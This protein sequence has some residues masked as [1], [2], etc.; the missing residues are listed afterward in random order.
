MSTSMPILA[1]IKTNDNY[2]HQPIGYK[3]ID[4]QRSMGYKLKRAIAE[5]VDNAIDA[6]ARKIQV[7]LLGDKR[8]AIEEIVILDN[9][10]GM[11]FDTLKNSFKLGADRVRSAGDLGYFGMGGTLGSLSFSAQKKT[12]TRGAGDNDFIGRS[13]DLDVCEDRDQWVTREESIIPS[14][15]EEL[16]TK[17]FGDK[18]AGTIIVHKALDKI[19]PQ[20]GDQI[21]KQLA[22]YFG[23]IFCEYITLGNVEITV[24]GER[25]EATDPLHWNDPDTMQLVD[26]QYIFKGN[27]YRIQA[28][29]LI[30]VAQREPSNYL[31]FNGRKPV[32][33]QGGYF[34]RSNRLI[35]GALTNSNGLEGF[36]AQHPTSMFFRFKISFDAQMDQAMGV[37]V[38]KSHIDMVQGLGDQIATVLNPL[39]KE[40]K[41]RAKDKKGTITQPSR[42]LNL[43]KAASV[44]NSQLVAPKKRKMSSRK[45][46]NVASVAAAQNKSTQTKAQATPYSHIEVHLGKRSQPV[47]LKGKNVE[48]NLDH[49]YIDKYYVNANSETRDAV[50][51]FF[52]SLLMAE[53]EIGEVDNCNVT[54]VFDNFFDKFN[55]KLRAWVGL[56]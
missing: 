20:R 30:R 3:F 37:N 52:T 41:K 55:S 5:H 22:A 47:T 44:A 32:L 36:W 11:D 10:S 45:G 35:K 43:S 40:A 49:P 28:V 23:E 46:N 4:S 8:S 19:R 53:T 24:D 56:V 38:Q 34:F 6:T 21:K 12:Y 15:Y 13:Y 39:L 51:S 17:T 48:I 31:S 25:V 14:Q 1:N 9:G 18:C 2:E 54:V 27:T 33:A 29:D 42:T 16:F 50:L 26:E 7:V